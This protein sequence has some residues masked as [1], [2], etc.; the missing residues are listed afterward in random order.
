[1]VTSNDFIL[2]ATDGYPLVAR[3]WVGNQASSPVAAALVN[4]GAGIGMSYYDRF[5]SFLAANGVPAVTYDYRGIG[6][7]RPR[8]LRG[9][10]ASVED[11]GSKD[12]AAA[13][14][15]L[16]TR[17]PGAR[18][19]IVGH[20]VG[21]FV[22]GF[23]TNGPMIDQMLLIGAHTGYWRDY[24]PRSRPAMYLLWHALM[25]FLTHLVGY[26]PGRRLHL[27]E[28]LPAG[29]A[30]EWANRRQPDFWW[31]RKT[32]DGALDT[33][34]RQ[35]ALGRFRAIR[36]PTLALRFSDDA[37]A[38]EAATNRV[39][40]LYQNCRVTRMVVEPADV[41][42]QKIGHFGFFRSRFRDTLWPRVLEWLQSEGLI[43]ER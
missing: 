12:C 24:A 25:P 29:V 2:A 37:F 13:L 9:F 23:V 21:G 6:K 42:G 33:A 28:D 36:A 31:N 14:Q 18:R 15:W 27:L 26:F 39:L 32:S 3:L 34:W 38:T 19:V 20:S 17:F 22:T 16:D 30:I 40:S 7:S 41:G 10:A 5:A 1:V 8:S 35:N 43:E 4:A 11:W